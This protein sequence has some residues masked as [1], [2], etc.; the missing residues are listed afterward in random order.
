MIRSKNY[1]FNPSEDKIAFYE[2]I[3]EIP[4]DTIYDLRLFKEILPFRIEGQTQG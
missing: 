4:G 3:I 1:L 2:D